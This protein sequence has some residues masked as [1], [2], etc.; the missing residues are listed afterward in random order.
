[1]HKSVKLLTGV[2]GAIF[3]ILGGHAPS[4][5][6]PPNTASVQESRIALEGRLDA[7]RAAVIDDL[8]RDADAPEAASEADRGT[9]LAQWLNWPN[10]NNGWANWGNWGNW[11]NW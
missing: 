2:A 6:M 7:L 8:S 10:W 11:R 1:M 4:A 9:H 3:G 5:A